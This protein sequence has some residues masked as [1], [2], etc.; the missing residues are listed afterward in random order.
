MW[1]WIFFKVSPENNLQYD[2]TEEALK[3]VSLTFLQALKLKCNQTDK[4]ASFLSLAWSSHISHGIHVRYT[5]ILSDSL[6]VSSLPFST[7]DY[8]SNHELNR[9]EWW[10]QNWTLGGKCS[11]YFWNV[12]LINIYTQIKIISPSLI[13]L[14]RCVIKCHFCINFVVV[15]TKVKHSNYVFSEKAGNY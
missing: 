3:Q 12:S 15:G 9:M 6:N 11:V 13:Y 2:P 8:S 7:R 14:L 10:R 1:R 4:V 5:M